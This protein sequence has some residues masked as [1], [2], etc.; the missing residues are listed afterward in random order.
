MTR[1]GLR[2]RPWTSLDEAYLL[3]HAGHDPLRDICKHLGKSKS[4]VTSKAHELRAA[5]H[6][7]DLRHYVSKL[8]ICP[9]C[10]CMRSSM[11]KH[12]ICE[13]CRKR[14]QLSAIHSRISRLLHQLPFEEREIYANTE[15][16]TESVPDPMP[17][18]PRLQGLSYYKR[19][20]AKAEHDKAMEAWQCRTLHRQ[21]KAAQKRKERIEKKIK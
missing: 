7:I 20:K 13:V 8:E 10:G 6:N 16:E 2:Q 12:G 1:K 15:A 9:A 17:R 11:A 19:C 18:A 4:A 3:Q 14:V 5:G 21:I